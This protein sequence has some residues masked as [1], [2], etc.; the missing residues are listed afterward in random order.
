MLLLAPNEV[1]KKTE[2]R[3]L[4]NVSGLGP[5]ANGTDLKKKIWET[6]KLNKKLKN[7]DEN[8]T[9]IERCD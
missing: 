6:R 1:L 2:D 4:L 8:D 7:T 5:S 9:E 3:I